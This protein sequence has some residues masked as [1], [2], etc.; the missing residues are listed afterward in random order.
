MSFV[1]DASAAVAWAFSDEKS[2]AA[3]LALIEVQRTFAIVPALWPFEMASALRK[4][5]KEGRLT[6]FQRAEFL[7]DLNTLDIRVE[8][9]VP[10]VDRL[11]GL[12]EQFNLSIYDAAYLDL[13]LT[14]HLPLATLDGDLAIATRSAGVS[15]ILAL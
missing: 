1:L 7:A 10:T 13:A 8:R 2:K 5:V 12:A 11:L 14:T 4:A 6:P 15:L 3:T 9:D